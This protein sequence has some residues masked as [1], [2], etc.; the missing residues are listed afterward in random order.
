[1][2][3]PY[4]SV[5]ASIM[6]TYGSHVNDICIY[7]LTGEK[8]TDQSPPLQHFDAVSLSQAAR[9]MHVP[10]Q[11]A[12]QTRSEKNLGSI[13]MII[14]HVVSV[15]MAA[16]VSNVRTAIDLEIG[17]G[18]LHPNSHLYKRQVANDCWAK[19]AR[20]LTWE[21]N[22]FFL[23]TTLQKTSGEEL[24]DLPLSF[25]QDLE[26]KVYARQILVSV[27]GHT[28][29]N[30]PG[31]MAYPRKLFPLVLKAAV[32]E[33]K[34]LESR[35]RPDVLDFFADIFA[36]ELGEAGIYSVPGPASQGAISV[37]PRAW[38]RL[39]SPARPVA[40]QLDKRNMNEAQALKHAREE[41]A[42]TQSL[43]N[44][45]AK[46]LIMAFG[47]KA[48]WVTLQKTS[49]PEEW[50]TFPAANKEKELSKDDYLDFTQADWIIYGHNNFD[51]TN[52]LYR[53]ALF[54][55]IGYTLQHPNTFTKEDPTLNSVTQTNFQSRLHASKWLHMIDGWGPN[56][57]QVKKPAIMNF[58]GKF[59]SLKV[60]LQDLAH[61]GLLK[62]HGMAIYKSAK[63]S[64]VWDRIPKAELNVKFD[65]WQRAILED[66]HEGA[67]IITADLFGRENAEKIM[68]KQDK[69]Y[70]IGESV[71][72]PANRQRM[73]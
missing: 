34:R 5:T 48:F 11:I 47:Y 64:L 23:L 69:M 6:Y 27:L 62:V 43:A 15:L 3:Q 12:E 32:G 31:R 70:G 45:S 66:E 38:T 33:V 59:N 61:M 73:Q 20:P 4:S 68:V 26:D 72:P 8:C 18:R 49:W 1:M 19:M 58:T 24:T 54:I 17:D 7:I 28:G 10:D 36:A 39:T 40:P 50:D 57:T 30:S 21:N 67:F 42:A 71:E 56:I 37:V 25:V 51:I 14:C 2:N 9:W 60:R 52:P 55:V 13:T 44:P 29:P 46:W 22:M 35:R 63:H 53:V 41:R 65:R 16:I